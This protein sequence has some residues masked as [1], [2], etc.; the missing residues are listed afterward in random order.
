MLW[1]EHFQWN[2]RINIWSRTSLIKDVFQSQWTITHSLRSLMESNELLYI[3]ILFSWS[4]H[5]TYFVS[6]LCGF[7]GQKFVEW[8]NTR[9]WISYVKWYSDEF[10]QITEKFVMLWGLT[11]GFMPKYPFVFNCRTCS[12]PRGVTRSQSGSSV[13]LHMVRTVIFCYYVT[14]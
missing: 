14:L 12:A 4:H 1:L 2:F 7:S 13:T 6:I 10:V 8:P 9:S 11:V 3:L 5:W